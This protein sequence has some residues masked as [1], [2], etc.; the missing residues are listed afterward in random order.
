MERSQVEIFKFITRFRLTVYSRQWVEYT[1]FERTLK[2]ETIWK[3]NYSM[4]SYIIYT[5]INY[6]KLTF[7]REYNIF[8]WKG[9][10]KRKRKKGNVAA[11]KIVCYD[12]KVL[13]LRNFPLSVTSALSKS[14]EWCNDQACLES[15]EPFLSCS[16]FNSRK[17]GGRLVK[18]SFSTTCTRR[19][20]VSNCKF[21]LLCNVS[22][23]QKIW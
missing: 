3:S 13:R 11:W 12:S 14:I 20:R 10:W 16:T 6:V 8:S 21:I 18:V 2:F 4:E 22:T 1:N 9:P 15:F 19:M 5:R 7:F 23:F 17:A